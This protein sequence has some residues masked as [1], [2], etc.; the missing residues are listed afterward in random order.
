[1]K[2]IIQSFFYAVIF[3]VTLFCQPE[4]GDKQIIQSTIGQ[5]KITVQVLDFR[6]DDPL[7]GAIIY[8]RDLKDTL[9]S[10]DVY[11]KASFEKYI[12]RNFQVSYVGY[13]YL[14][15]RIND[16][17]DNI[18]VKLKIYISRNLGLL[19]YSPEVDSLEKA[20]SSDAEDDLDE[21]I[22][23]LFYDTAPTE[24]QIAF[25]QKYEF[26]FTDGKNKRIDYRDSYNEVVLDFLS[27]KYNLNIRKE[28][29]DICWLNN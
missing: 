15:F 17:T 10:T 25:T 21:D 26:K 20:G 11:G 8:S 12:S 28:L 3:N 7:I 22:I 13:E 14:C 29:R 6:T 19:V 1:M 27:D 2:N 23:Q 4:F 24:E 16:D 5:D 9:S 18:I